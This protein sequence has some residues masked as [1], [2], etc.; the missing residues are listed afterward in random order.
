VV[1]GCGVHVYERRVLWPC[2]GL[3][4]SVGEC[5]DGEARVG[6]WVGEQSHRS[7][8]KR[9]WDGGIPEGKPGEGVT[10]EK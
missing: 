6:R 7:R 4:P 10:F 8:V 3:M 5:Q 1:P 2:E 9:G